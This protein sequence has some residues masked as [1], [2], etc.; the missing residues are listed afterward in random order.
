MSDDGGELLERDEALA[1]LRVIRGLLERATIYRAMSSATAMVAGVLA[2]A[3]SVLLVAL[4][5]GAYA[6][7]A[8]WMGV[9]LLVHVFNGVQIA[10][11]ARQRGQ[12]FFSA[13]M[14]LT[15]KAVSPPLASG[16]AIGAV[17]ALAFIQQTSSFPS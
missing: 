10:I 13:G 5:M 17:F 12:P 15:I 4:G 6:F 16:A 8:T 11:A 7:L 14:R 9:F 3:A 2:M 1:D